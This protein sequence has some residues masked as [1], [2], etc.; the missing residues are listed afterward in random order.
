MLNI[1]LR[2]NFSSQNFSLTQVGVSSGRGSIASTGSISIPTQETI[3]IGVYKCER[4]TI[5]KIAK[6]KVKK[7]EIIC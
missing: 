2:I 6:K 1:I 7:I 4:V 3:T 5:K